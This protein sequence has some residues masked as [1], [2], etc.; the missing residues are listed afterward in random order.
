[1]E[2]DSNNKSEM[3]AIGQAVRYLTL[4]ANQNHSY[5]SNCEQESSHLVRLPDLMSALRTPCCRKF[6]IEGQ[7]I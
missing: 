6:R 1:M 3:R 2:A 5:A 4:A 7:G